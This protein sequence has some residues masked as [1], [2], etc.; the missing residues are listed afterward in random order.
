MGGVWASWS[1][2]WALAQMTTAKTKVR[3][4]RRGRMYFM[5][6]EFSGSDGTA[7]AVASSFTLSLLFILC[8]IQR[9]EQGAGAAAGKGAVA[10]R[11]LAVLK[12]LRSH[13]PEKDAA[14][15]RVQRHR[16]R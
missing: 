16:H 14:V 2:F 5:V 11:L 12:K 6:L 3:D 9:P 4:R 8:F 13:Q 15:R 7:N 10:L 1:N